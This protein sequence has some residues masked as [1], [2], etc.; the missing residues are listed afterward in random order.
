MVLKLYGFPKSTA[1]RRVAHIL[2]EKKVPFEFIEQPTNTNRPL[3]SR[4]NPLVKFP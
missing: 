3:T 4:S 1:T 2:H